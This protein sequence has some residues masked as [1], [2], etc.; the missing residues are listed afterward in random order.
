MNEK[1]LYIL[2]E[3][4]NLLSEDYKNLALQIAKNKAMKVDIIA[5]SILNRAI[6][7]NEGFKTLFLEDNIYA[8]CHLIRIQLDSLIRYN[9][10]LIAKD[11]SIIDHI[12]EGKSI[13]D[14]KDS[15][16]KTK[17]NDHFLVSQLSIRIP[18][19]E[20]LY[21]K[22]CGWIHYSNE[23]I[24]R[25]KTNPEIKNVLF[26]LEIGN[27]DNYTLDEKIELF[28]DMLMISYHIYYTIND[29]SEAK[30]TLT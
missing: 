17:F 28:S 9:S 7:I 23:H 25:I 2:V 1:D 16:L 11:K 24:E 4:L 30:K 10:I 6:S 14:F 22:Y 15:I 13:R 8:A 21:Q 29:W 27:T 20:N 18:E 19:I 12:L 3:K 26:R 5:L